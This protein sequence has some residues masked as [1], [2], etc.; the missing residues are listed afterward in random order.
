MA[1]LAFGI[2]AH[3]APPATQP[4]QPV[5]G[6]VLK[7]VGMVQYSTIGKNNWVKAKVGDTLDAGTAIRTGLRSSALIQLHAT[8]IVQIKSS[9]RVALTDLARSA[10]S[11]KTRIFLD[12]GTV[13]GGIVESQYYSDFQIACPAAVLSRE[14]TWGF[15]MSYDPAT[16]HFYVGLDTEG[17]VRV[18]QFRTG[19]SITLTPGQFVTQAMAAWI[20][21]AFF[22]QMVSFADPFG[23]TQIEQLFYA[24]NSDGR[25]VIDPTGN[26]SFQNSVRQGTQVANEQLAQSRIEGQILNNQILRILNQAIERQTTPVVTP[27]ATIDYQFGNFGTHIPNQSVSPTTVKQKRR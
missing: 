20:Q 4:A 17:L 9:T 18:T 7:V 10:T 22:Q 15:E 13:R 6:K 24:T 3:A 8:A 12:Y 2:V 11:Q 14:G 25:T 23:T 5:R 26:Q 1:V 27:G 16:G 21:T 19:K